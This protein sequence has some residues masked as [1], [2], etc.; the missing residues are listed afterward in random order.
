MQHSRADLRSLL[1]GLDADGL[2]HQPQEAPRSI[3][4][5]LVHL[6]FVELM[7]TAWTFD[8]TTPEGVDAFLDWSRRVASERMHELAESSDDA[9]THAEWSGAQAPE[10]W[11]AR[12]AVRRLLWHERLHMRGL[13]RQLA[14]PPAGG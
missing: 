14:R 1:H 12:K 13:Q 3:R 5:V 6:A 2:A 9:L 11:T 8:H 10:P 7:Y 4:E